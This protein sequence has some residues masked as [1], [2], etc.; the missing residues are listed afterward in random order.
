ME[1]LSNDLVPSNSFGRNLQGVVTP[2]ADGILAESMKE[3]DPI[4]LIKIK[5]MKMENGKVKVKKIYDKTMMRTYFLDLMKRFRLST[6][7]SSTQNP[8]ITR[9]YLWLSLL[10]LSANRLPPAPQRI[11]YTSSPIYGNILSLLEIRLFRWRG[12]NERNGVE[13]W[14]WMKM[15]DYIY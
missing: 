15:L 3:C 4:C 9:G 5:M 7:F 8:R 11:E 10:S 2:S 1:N 12:R 13:N 6:F 14:K